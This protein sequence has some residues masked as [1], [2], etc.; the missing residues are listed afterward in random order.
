MDIRKE[1]KRN[2]KK[3][4][5]T[6]HSCI[7]FDQSQLRALLF[8][9]VVLDWYCFVELK[10]GLISSNQ[11]PQP[12]A[13]GHCW[14]VLH[15]PSH[16]SGR[17]PVTARASAAACRN[18]VRGSTWGWSWDWLKLRWRNDWKPNFTGDQSQM[19]H[20]LWCSVLLYLWIVS[21]AS[22]IRTTSRVFNQFD[23][24]THKQ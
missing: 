20:I 18:A 7:W 14:P 9:L 1:I 23:I 16:A 21:R 15:C 8:Y 17:K 12:I 19:H 11:A 4:T 6:S 22:N 3:G 10:I 2:T 5:S 13:D 24:Q